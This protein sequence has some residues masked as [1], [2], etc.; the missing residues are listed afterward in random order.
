MAM[1]KTD[2]EVDLETVKGRAVKG[3]VALTGRTFLLQIISFFGFFFLTVFLGRAEIGLFFAISELVAILGYFSDIGL[4]AALIQK[5]EKPDLRDIRSTFTIQQGLVL[6][7][8]FL[9]FIFTPW[10]KGFY[11]ISQAGIWLL[12]ALTA[13]FFLASLKT[14]PSVLLERK[15]RFDLLVVVEIV[16]TMLFYG[17]AVVLAWQGFGVI[18]Y[19][20]AVLIRGLAGVILIYILSP[21]PI[22]FAFEIQSLRHLLKFGV[23]YQANTFLAVVKDRLMNVFLWKIIGVEGVGIL[24]WAQKWAQMP[25]RFIM[26]SVMKVTFPAYS[27]MQEDKEEL[28]KAIEKTLYFVSLLTFPMLVGIALLAHPLMNII[29]KYQKWEVALLALG[30]YVIN[31]AWASVTT[32]LTNALAAVGKIKIVFKLMVMWTVLTWA[33]FPV[34]AIRFGY[35][36]VAAASA[37]VATSSIIAILLAQRHLNFDFFSSIKNPVIA[38]ISMGILLWFLRPLLEGSFFGLIALVFLG[39]IAYILLIWILVG[40]EFIADLR[41]LLLAFRKKT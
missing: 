3:V 16:E 8:V 2:I 35:N 29:P 22:G 9:V 33:L 18:S 6:T 24:G 20:W 4:A 17:L 15:L 19:A 41:R 5:K 28:K 7:L 1:D 30:L 25:L 34:L 12:W 23:P 13:G 11:N 31:S 39:G 10:L 27:R 38:T 32:P 37:L 26:D 14:I 40:Q 21:W 36:G